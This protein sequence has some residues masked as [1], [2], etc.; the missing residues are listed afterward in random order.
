MKNHMEKK[1]VTLKM[2]IYTPSDDKLKYK[3][4]II[5]AYGGGFVNG[6]R[7]EKS[8]VQL[9]T[10]FAKRGFVTAT[11]DY[12]LG[13]NLTDSELAKRAVYRALQDGRSAVRFFRKNATTYNIDPNKIFISGH[14]AGGF[15]AIHN[16]YL[17][18]DSERPA[19]TRNYFGRLDLGRLD[20]IGENKYYKNGEKI[21]GRANGVMAMAGAIGELSYIENA[22]DIHGIYFHSTDD[23]TV[24]FESGEPFSFLNWIPGI[25]LPTVKGGGQ[26]QKRSKNIGLKHVLNKYSGRGHSVHTN[27][28]GNLHDD[29]I[30]ETAKF[31]YINFL[32]PSTGKILSINDNLKTKSST[33]I[34][35]Y[36]IQQSNATFY[37]WEITGGKII[38]QN[39]AKEKITIQWNENSS[40]RAITVTPYSKHLAKG[41]ELIFNINSNS[42]LITSKNKAN[43]F[44]N[45]AKHIIN[46]KLN[47]EQSYQKE[48]LILIFN[49]LGQK[50]L[51]KTINNLNK[52]NIIPLD[53][54]HLKSGIYIFKAITS[55]QSREIISKRIFIK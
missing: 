10:E 27:F 42:Y 34:Q 8:M 17:N 29:I 48:V 2:D 18:K 36:E 1:H 4:V 25:N 16:V 37:D 31:F 43:L 6:K 53:I 13:M 44:P 45:P 20:D 11:I 14:S 12:R 50:I 35:Q 51:D 22:S 3:P 32:K 55:D 47:N 5:F 49:P 38:N 46:L 40:K 28:F 54:S 41:D 52:D 7:T 39:D 19:S 21:S 23:S 15:L 24:P 26:I 33:D 30:S 9:C